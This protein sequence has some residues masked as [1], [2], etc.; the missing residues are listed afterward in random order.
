MF[1]LYYQAGAGHLV[2]MYTS[3]LNEQFRGLYYIN[4][5]RHRMDRDKRMDRMRMRLM[6]EKG[7]DMEYEAEMEKEL[8]RME[9]MYQGMIV[10]NFYVS[11]LL[12]LCNKRGST[13]RFEG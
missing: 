8:E 13:E 3:E 2:M 12:L 7:F 5:D 6:W 1:F 9:H 11:R 10:G 4:F